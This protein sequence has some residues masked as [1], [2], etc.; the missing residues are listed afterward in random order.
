MALRR[1]LAILA[2]AAGLAGPALAQKSADTL[3]ISWR[4]AVPNVDP[5]YNTQRNGIM[6]ADTATKRRPQIAVV[7]VS[8]FADDLTGQRIEN[9][10][11]LDKPFG[12]MQL[13][14]A[15]RAALEQ[16]RTGMV[17]A[18]PQQAAA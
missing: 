11:L 2:L 14:T 18:I 15:L 6:L 10:R 9:Y 3:R 13:Q 7:L 1:L 16:A 8:G 4:D 17:A 12:K 5:Y